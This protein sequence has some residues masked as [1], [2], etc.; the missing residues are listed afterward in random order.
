MDSSSPV[1]H[2]VDV[3]IMLPYEAENIQK[4]IPKKKSNHTYKVL[5]WREALWPPASDA[6]QAKFDFTMGIHFNHAQVLNP[7]WLS[8]PY[9]MYH[10]FPLVE[11][12]TKFAI[13]LV[14]DC[15]TKSKREI[16]LQHLVDYLGADRI[17]LY[18]DCY[19]KFP[20]TEDALKLIFQYKFFLSFENTIQNGYVTEKL[21][22]QMGMPPIPV[23]Y[24][25]EHSPNITTIPSYIK[26]SDYKT[27]KAL[28]KHLLHLDQNDEE[29]NKYH[30]W[31]KNPKLLDEK[32]LNYI[33]K[34]LPGPREWH[35][36][37]KTYPDYQFVWKNRGLKQPPYR[38]SACCRL[39]DPHY[40]ESLKNEKDKKMIGGV[41][42]EERIK[43]KYFGGSFER[44][45]K[46]ALMH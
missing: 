4:V 17:N 24:G 39:C 27:P 42:N 15:K 45:G 20:R 11:K 19:K 43:R 29:Y 18:G 28:A 2:D 38:R 32:F 14:S 31:R 36:I 41:W 40:L 10:S 30:E 3:I 35:E 34:N 26:V 12:K 33:A 13:A 37:K 7:S 44:P 25:T 23:Y 1:P 6:T 8:T 21:F 5:Y 9:S 22:F 46:E 16:Y